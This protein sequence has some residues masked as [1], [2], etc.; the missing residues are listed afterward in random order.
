MRM[1]GHFRG[2]IAVSLLTILFLGLSPS[3][4]A[5]DVWTA[6]KSDTA[7]IPREIVPEERRAAPGGLPDAL[8]E[9]GPKPGDISAAW[10]A[11]RTNRYRH[12]IL[13]DTFEGSI[14]RVATRAGGYRKLALPD[15]EVFEDRYPRLADLDG[16]GKTE[17]I[18]IRTSITHGA[19]VT[20]YG[21]RDGKLSEVATTEFIGHANRWLNIA[22]IASFR[23]GSGK[24]I[25]YVQTPHIGG[26]LFLYA[27][28]EGK[29]IKVGEKPGFSNHQTGSTEMRLSAIADI[30]GDGAPELAVPSA[31][32]RQLRIVG[33]NRGQL[34]DR[35]V[36]DL[37][38]TIDKAIAV[39]GTEKA[40]RL[41]AGLQSGEVY[42][43]GR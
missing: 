35:A 1:T 4:Q 30:N 36:A 3:V 29:L 40:T 23:G 21:L 16:D 32:R 26:T 25:A 39:H 17:I 7:S 18:T 37:P 24:E 8:I 12:G 38:A 13:G 10:Y 43:V 5:Q 15:T 9:T 11:G 2:V 34:T 41:I 27:L 22:G 6:K 28:E 42:S 14:L 33:F 19:A 20:V 31:D